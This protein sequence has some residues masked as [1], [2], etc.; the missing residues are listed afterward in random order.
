MVFL[1]KHLHRVNE[2][3]F[4]EQRS[5]WYQFLVVDPIRVQGRRKNS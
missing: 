3:E 4:S 5:K 1:P 2:L